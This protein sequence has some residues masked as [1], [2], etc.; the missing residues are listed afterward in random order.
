M[1]KQSN[2]W[3]QAF[4][5]LVAVPAVAILGIAVIF[6]LQRSNTPLVATTSQPTVSLTVSANH[7][8]TPDYLA[9]SAAIKTQYPEI[10]AARPTGIF[11]A[12]A[13]F[14]HE[15]Y[16][17][18]NAWQQQVNGAWANVVAGATQGDPEQGV[19]FTAWEFPNAA[20]WKFVNTPL[21]VGSVKIVAEQD[22]R[23]TLQSDNG[24]LFY[25]DVPSQSF[26]SSL[27]EVAPT[28]TPPPTYTP[29]PPKPTP[30]GSSGYPSTCPTPTLAPYPGPTIQA[31]EAP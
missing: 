28:I 31:T 7:T 2:S 18:Q 26:V 21:K 1:T 24:T 30:C 22:Y 12:R 17:M 9:I 6:V 11:D 23:L 15:G 3:L 5:L 20:I 16:R 4:G 27:T 19:I 10:T 25:F 29:E 13:E 14:F 8:A